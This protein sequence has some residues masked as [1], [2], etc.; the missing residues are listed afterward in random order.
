MGVIAMTEEIKLCPFC[1]AS[2]E[3]VKVKR[4]HNEDHF[5]VQCIKMCVYT[6]HYFNKELAIICWNTRV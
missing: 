3:L 2:A 1:G 6:L 5:R 4:N